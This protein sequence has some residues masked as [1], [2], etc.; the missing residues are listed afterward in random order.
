MVGQIE[1]RRKGLIFLT[2]RL[3]IISVERNEKCRGEIEIL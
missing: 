2:D 1:T 3:Q